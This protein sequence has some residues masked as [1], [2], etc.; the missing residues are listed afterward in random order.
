MTIITR[1]RSNMTK[2][3]AIANMTRK[4]DTDQDDDNSIDDDELL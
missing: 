4:N 3:K 2:M 1:T